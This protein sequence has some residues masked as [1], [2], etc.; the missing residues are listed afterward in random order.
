LVFGSTRG[1]YDFLSRVYC[2]DRFPGI[3]YL[4]MGI[5]GAAQV[6]QQEAIWLAVISISTAPA[7]RNADNAER[8]E[9]AQRC[10]DHAPLN[11]VFYELLS[12]DY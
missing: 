12:G 7:H 3:R 9:L 11:A 6:I 8:I 2:F 4:V 10:W 1:A 5:D